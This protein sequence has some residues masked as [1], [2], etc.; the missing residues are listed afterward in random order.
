MVKISNSIQIRCLFFLFLFLLPA[1]YADASTIGSG[2]VGFSF[3]SYSGAAYEE[4]SMFDYSDDHNFINSYIRQGKLNGVDIVGNGSIHEYWDY[5]NDTI[6]RVRR[7]YT[8]LSINP[9]DNIN[10]IELTVNNWYTNLIG[11]EA[12]TF[13]NIE[14]GESFKLG[15]FTYQNGQVISP[16]ELSFS[17]ETV[18]DDDGFTQDYEGTLVFDTTSNNPAINPTPSERAD[19]F[20]IKEETDMEGVWVYETNEVDPDSGTSLLNLGTVE[21][22]GRIGSIELDEFKNPTGG[23]FL[24]AVPNNTIPE[25]TTIFLFGLGLLSFAGVNRKK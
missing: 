25:P 8:D 22:W 19:Y 11:F 13:E 12:A 7:H 2:T 16:F 17:L 21:L 14:I 10:E 15:T 5:N 24:A 20:H 23:A 18:S 3:T 9:A 6:D 4:V 1:K